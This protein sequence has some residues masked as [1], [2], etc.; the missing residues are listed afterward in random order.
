MSEFDTTNWRNDKILNLPEAEQKA[1][2]L[3]AQGKRLVTV[4]GTFDLLHVGHLDQLE[5]AKQQGDALFVGVNSDESVRQGKGEGRPFVPVE[6]RAAL[7]A[8]LV[9]VNYVVVID[10]D[11]SEVPKKFIEV[12]R[13]AV[14]VNGSD[15]GDPT[16]WIEWPIMQ[17]HGTRGFVVQRRNDLSTSKLIEKI[18]NS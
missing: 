5:E 10:A 18:R 16:E 15:Y 11:Y 2:E 8:A 4:N 1:A 3:H 13:P 6:A 12:I 14:H 9:C 7:L 17:K